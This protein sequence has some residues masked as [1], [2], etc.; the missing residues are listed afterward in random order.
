LEP[1]EVL[2]VEGKLVVVF[3]RELGFL[4]VLEVLNVVDEGLDQLV[5]SISLHQFL[6]LKVSQLGVGALEDFISHVVELT[7]VLAF[8]FLNI[9]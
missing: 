8:V 4:L 5:R 1:V 6:E 2:G 7:H 3:R 9:K